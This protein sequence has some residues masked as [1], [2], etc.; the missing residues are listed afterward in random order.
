MEILGAIEAAYSCDNVNQNATN[1]NKTITQ[2]TGKDVVLKGT[3][4]YGTQGGKAIC[5]NVLTTVI[6]TIGLIFLVVGYCCLGGA[7]FEWL[8]AGTEKESV[9]NDRRLVE[10]IV[11]Q[12]AANLY[13]RLQTE[14]VN[15]SLDTVRTISDVL[16]QISVQSYQVGD[17]G[18]WD[19]QAIGVGVNLDWTFPGAVLFSVTTLTTIGYGFIAPATVT[20]RIIC[21]IY[22]VFGIPV[23]ML[24]IANLGLWFARQ[25]R[26]VHRAVTKCR[27]QN[28]DESSITEVNTQTSMVLGRV[29]NRDLSRA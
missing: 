5:L 8:E 23:T 7:V 20:G 6:S 13:A 12:H 14:S 15:Q 26:K 21:V 3:V 27:N 9:I 18:S 1:D 10:A 4:T 17:S 24:A 11:K 29:C 19:G 22:S 16:R 25:V 28:V 2:S